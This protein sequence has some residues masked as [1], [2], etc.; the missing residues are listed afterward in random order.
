ML[1]SHRSRRAFTLIELLV[2]IA[3][4]AVLVALL[5]PAVQQAREAARRAQCKGNLKQIGLA[6]NNYHETF[7]TFPPGNNNH[8]IAGAN[9]GWGQSWW[10][11]ILPQFDQQSIFEQWNHEAVS[12]G[13][14]DNNNRT[15]VNG[16][17]LPSAMCPSSPMS[18]YELSTNNGISPGVPVAHYAG[19]SGSF[20]D[21][22][23]R[24]M[25]GNSN[26]GKASNYGVLYFRSRVRFAD[27]TDGSTNTIAVAE[28]SD[29]CIETATGQQR[30]AIAAWPHGMFM[31]SSGFGDRTFNAVTLRHPVGYKQAYGGHNFNG[32]ACETTGLGV[33]GNSGI[34]NPI[35]SAHVGGAH[36]LLV[37]G[38]TRFLSEN[39]NLQTFLNAGVRDDGNQVDL[40]VE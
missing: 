33:C 14:T 30:I 32:A 3:I 39:I 7:N 21:P 6:L 35:Q 13:Y 2:V 29:W 22:Q 16:K 36:V 18:P 38:S 10:V 40:G 24:A 15:L 4:I 31:G 25:S 28:Q 34:N 20:P 9:S 12:S 1:R 8:I 26:S 5:L 23:G 19:I 37:D 27:I 17:K 11:S